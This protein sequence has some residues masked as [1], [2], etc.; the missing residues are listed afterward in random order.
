MHFSVWCAED[1]A[2][3]PAHSGGDFGEAMEGMYRQVC[4]QWP[5]GTVPAAF[6]T[7][8]PSP[9][10]VLL[11]SGGIDPVT[12]SPHAARVAKELG[13]QARILTV[14]NAGHGLMSEGSCARDLAYRFLN[15]RTAEGAAGIDVSCLRQIPRPL[16]WRMPLPVSA[17][18]SASAIGQSGDGKT[19]EQ[20]AKRTENR[21][22]VRR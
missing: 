18:A 14:Q 2:R 22:G 11:L 21:E 8:S 17:A 20:A 10:P 1:Y 13:P 12:P 4:S 6:Y 9:A 16:A 19:T 5:R 15:A 7:L 3:M